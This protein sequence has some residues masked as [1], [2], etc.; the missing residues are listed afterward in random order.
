[1]QATR[2]TRDVGLV[3]LVLVARAASAMALASVGAPT[4]ATAHVEAA[5]H[6]V[7]CHGSAMHGATCGVPRGSSMPPPTVCWIQGPSIELAREAPAPRHGL[8]AS[9]RG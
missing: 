5:I 6:L 2:R 7:P 3:S 8:V 9:G 1:M 4:A